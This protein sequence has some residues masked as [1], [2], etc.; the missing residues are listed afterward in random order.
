MP[1][2]ATQETGFCVGGDECHFAHGTA[3]LRPTRAIVRKAARVRSALGTQRA[4]EQ[5]Q[6]QQQQGCVSDAAGDLGM[7]Q[8]HA[9]HLCALLSD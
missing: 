9:Q 7:W 2:P 5:Q 1:T 4:I 3:E 6:Q 8:R